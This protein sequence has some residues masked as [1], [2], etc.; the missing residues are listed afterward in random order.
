MG[1]AAGL[2]TVRLA[3]RPLL[4]G[5]LADWETSESA[6]KPARRLNI[7]LKRPEEFSRRA[8]GAAQFFLGTDT[9]AWG[10]IS[11]GFSAGFL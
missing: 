2:D 8:R 9:S 11:M 6:L 10:A 5:S 4:V 1:E 7:P 3:S